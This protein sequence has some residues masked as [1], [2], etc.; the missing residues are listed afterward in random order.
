MNVVVDHEALE[1][2][3]K[4]LG[5]S[6]YSETIDHLASKAARRAKLMEA[7]D[8]LAEGP[9]PW[10]PGFVEEV[11]PDVAE[12]LRKNEGRGVTKVAEAPMKTRRRD[13]R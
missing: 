3:R 6:S 5:K 7:I 9:D 4:A 1:E 11:A 2:A 12:W 13:P 10:Y 8:A